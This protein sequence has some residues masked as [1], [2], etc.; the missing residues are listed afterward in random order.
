MCVSGQQASHKPT[1]G[2]LARLVLTKIALKPAVLA[3]LAPTCSGQDQ[4]R[5]RERADTASFER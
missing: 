4:H 1:S 3:S 2:A 5:V